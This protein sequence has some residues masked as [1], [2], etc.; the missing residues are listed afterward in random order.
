VGQLIPEK[1][2]DLLLDAVALL[3]ARGIDARLDVVGRIDGWVQPRYQAYRERVQARAAEADLDGR[4]RFL[5]WRDDVPALMAGAAVH[6]C[7]SRPEQREAF[8]LVVVEAKQAGVPSVVT[9]TGALPE[10]V[11][12]GV[13]G[14]VCEHISAEDLA[15]GLGRFLTD[16]TLLAR[17]GAAALASAARFNRERF[18]AEW[19]A[20][21]A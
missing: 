11:A 16:P 19:K 13:D 1:G 21:I 7:P 14:W 4:V 6:C 18:A 9:P 2:V 8:G 15:L 20:V 3:A 17:A 10:L 12:H 5:G